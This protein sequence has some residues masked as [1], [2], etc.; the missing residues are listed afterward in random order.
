MP[1]SIHAGDL[2]AG[3]YRLDD[4]LTESAGGRFWLAH[5]QVLHR[6][7]AVH[8]IA[9]TDERAEGLIAAARRTAPHHDR[10][11]LRVLDADEADERCYV[12]NEWGQGTSL[13]NRLA[14]NGP[15]Q[16]RRAAWVASELADSLAR[17]H[18]AGLDHGRM[19]PENVLIDLNGQVRIIGFAVD[20][21][22][23]GLPPGRLSAD[24]IDTVAVLYAAL[25]GKWAGVS[26]SRLESAPIDHGQVLR[27][28]RVRAGIPRQ[29]DDLCD[30]VINSPATAP[31]SSYD[32]STMAGVCEAL[33]EF[34]G[35]PAGMDTAE[36]WLDHH[37][38]TV[39]AAPWAVDASSP[40][41]DS[42]TVAVAPVDAEPAPDPESPSGF[43][44][45]IDPDPT[46]VVEPEAAAAAAPVT[47]LPTQAGIP[48]FDENN[49]VGWV[50]ARSSPPA[51]PERT[52]EAQAKPLFAPA[53]PDGEPVRRGRSG[54]TPAPSGDYWPWETGTGVGAG[55]IPQTS[56]HHDTANHVVPGRRWFWLAM[57]VALGVLV[58]VS[59]VA[60]YQLG[61]G[62]GED[63]DDP[64][65]SAGQSTAVDPTP[66]TE[67]TAVDFDPQGA[68]PREENPDLVPLALDGDPATAWQTSFYK[69]NFGPTGLKDG[70]GL[71][72]DLG[73]T[74][75]VREIEVATLG[76][77][78]SVSAYV[79]GK[80]PAGVAKLTPIGTQAGNGVLTFDL[81][82][83]VSGRFVTVWL[84]SIPPIEGEFRG[85]IA[86]VVVKG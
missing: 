74:L 45:A 4:L 60:A 77:P 51:P 34:V 23:H 24:H 40:Q 61:V 46:V 83:A 58:L 79:T 39:A 55:A 50:Q 80:A 64:G 41:P 85:A 36:S 71:L 69:Q 21:A 11:L 48:I 56:D 42:P 68:E 75:S 66:F 63:T 26:S 44:A 13:D 27:P 72:V 65:A 14:S 1:D 78:T 37:S 82:E 15:M 2:L 86:E 3:R 76:G 84:T 33:R 43:S 53:P 35:D 6:P 25:T 49:D 30:Q 54:A 62:P 67:L 28:R 10:R 31:R 7:V 20:A 59:S 81:D 8:I 9:R 5:D 47:D 52:D 38:V 16:P 73:S 22:L 29:L 17:A 57:L 12:V 19:V 70:V 18:E 32:L